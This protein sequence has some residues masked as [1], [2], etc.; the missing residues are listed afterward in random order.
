[1]SDPEGNLP[2]WPPTREPPPLPPQQRNGCL[3]ALMVGAGLI[4]LVPGLCVLL[5]NGDGQ[6][7][8]QNLSNPFG[9]LILGLFLGGIA[10]V[11]FAVS[12]MRR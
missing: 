5:V 1:M 4:L 12:R 3:T 9:I 7:H 8:L 2:P 6:I 10:L 11:G